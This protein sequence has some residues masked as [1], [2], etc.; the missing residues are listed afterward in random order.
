MTRARLSLITGIVLLSVAC[1]LPCG[2][3]AEWS[4]ASLPYQ[5]PTPDMLENQAAEVAILEKK[6]IVYVVVSGTLALLGIC[7]SAYGL[8]RGRAYRRGRLPTVP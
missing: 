4:G 8:R 2:V 1:L 3:L 5:D 7:A 6:L